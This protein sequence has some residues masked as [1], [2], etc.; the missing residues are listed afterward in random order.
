MYVWYKVICLYGL[1]IYHTNIVCPY[2]INDLA[3]LLLQNHSLL[4]VRDMIYTAPKDH[5]A[6]QAQQLLTKIKVATEFLFQIKYYI[7]PACNLQPLLCLATHLVSSTLKVPV[8]AVLV[9]RM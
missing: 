5:P 3:M 7:Y 9:V 8:E 6:T 2:C 4:H 1:I